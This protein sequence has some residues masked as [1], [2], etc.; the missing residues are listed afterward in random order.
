MAPS[1]SPARIIVLDGNPGFAGAAMRFI[2][3]LP[4]YVHAAGDV[5]LV[6]LGLAGLDL[7]RRLKRSNPLLRVIALALFPTPELL[8]EAERA[9]IDAVVSKEA[10]ADELPQAL[11]RAGV[12]TKRVVAGAPAPKTLRESEEHFRRLTQLSSDWYWEQDAEL[13]F[14]HTGGDAEARGGITPEQHVGLRRWELPGTEPLEGDW[15]AH[16]AVLAARQPFRDF[17]IKRAVDERRASYVSVSGEPIFGDDGVFR[18]YRGIARDVTASHQA[19][20]DLRESERRL[21]TLIASLPG[22]AYRCR[23]DEH[24]TMEFVSEGT[25]V[26]TGYAPDD[27]TSGR[28]S[29]GSLVHEEDRER[30]WLSTQ[31]AL[32]R[33]LPYVMEYRIRT[34]EGAEKWIWERGVGVPGARGEVVALEGFVSD[35]TERKLSEQRLAQL[36]QFDTLTGLPNRLLLH[37]RLAQSLTQARRHDRRVGVLFVDLDRFKLVNDTLGHY[38]GDL[39][40]AKVARRLTRC[41]RPGDTVGRISGDEFAVVL[42]DLAHADDA[43]MVAQKV[44]ET[45]A[46]PYHLAGSEAFATASIGIATFPGDGD[47][48]EDLLRNADM[49]MYRAKE[50]T[51]NTFCFFTAEM[52]L[53]SAERMQLNN[54]L[55]HA[56]ERSEFV[57]HYQPKVELASGALTGFEALLRWNHPTRGLVPPGQF[58]AALEESGLIAP[59]GEWVLKEAC[60]QIGRWQRAGLVP[61]P[62]AVNLSAKQF[63]RHDLDKLV[64]GALAAAGVAPALLELEITE[65]CLM[66]DPDQAVRL[67]NRLRDAGVRI[68]VDDFGTGH[69]SLSY[70]TRLPLTALKIDRSFVRDAATNAQAAS[71]VRAVIDM[72]HNLRFT[73]VAEG[74]ETERQV[75]FL[76]RHA[77]DQAQGYH[78]GRPCSAEQNARWLAPASIAA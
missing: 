32:R 9:G 26:L 10:F 27:F 72:A 1:A 60:A 40:I 12:V 55:R 47:D 11:A 30:C 17:I 68:S 2:E 28:V 57:L 13:R 77:C 39:L 34:A 20:L 44:L 31:E 37:D 76:R 78:Y 42:A 70:L 8:A 64:S 54:D 3:S 6:D 4:G 66:E 25:R 75:A 59:V 71:I 48:A 45:L 22:A 73:V 52:N 61:V 53:R 23:N 19:M 62:V 50:S 24:W 65:S 33:N 43:A 36:A 5:V 63:R 14:A 74:V 15:A 18:G 41:V 38:A 67:L 46:E 51:R 7:A 35:V 56:I 29:Y 69:S 49:A 21:S 16:Q 58:V